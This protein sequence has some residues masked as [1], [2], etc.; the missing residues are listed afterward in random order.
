[1]HMPSNIPRRSLFILDLNRADLTTEPNFV[2]L[3][4]KWYYNW[5][6][7]KSQNIEEFSSI[8]V[9]KYYSHQK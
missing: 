6:H 5:K 2:Q 9:K 7:R 8:I 3:H 1:M 4:N